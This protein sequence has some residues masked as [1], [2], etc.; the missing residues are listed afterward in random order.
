M[1]M[2]EILFV[3]GRQANYTLYT[4]HNTQKFNAAI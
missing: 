2:S 1:D 3:D 4:K